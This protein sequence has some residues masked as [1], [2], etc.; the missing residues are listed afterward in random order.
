[1]WQVAASWRASRDVFTTSLSVLQ[2]DDM[3]VRKRGDSLSQRGV[4]D[5]SLSMSPRGVEDMSLSVSQ[6][7]N[8]MFG[9]AVLL[10]PHGK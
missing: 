5:M 3:V 7:T 2:G 4:E 1:M 6:G 8:S 9:M 10:H